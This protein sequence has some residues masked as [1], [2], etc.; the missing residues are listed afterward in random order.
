MISIDTDTASSSY[1]HRPD[2]P[3]DHQGDLPA[4]ATSQ[5]LPPEPTAPAESG[6]GNYCLRCRKRDGSAHG[7]RPGLLDPVG[8]R[9]R[10]VVALA[11]LRPVCRRRD[12]ADRN[13]DDPVG[14]PGR[15]RVFRIVLAEPGD[16]VLVALVVVRPDVEIAG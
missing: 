2:D 1:R 14:V 5:G 10:L 6:R 11:G 4:M 3:G 13:G 9:G 16:R 12:V 15:E 7:L 8:R